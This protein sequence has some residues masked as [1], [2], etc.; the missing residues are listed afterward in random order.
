[1]S[2]NITDAA[3]QLCKQT[4]DSCKNFD[5]KKHINTIKTGADF[6]KSECQDLKKNVGTD[7]MDGN[8]LIVDAL[9][10][11]NIE[12]QFMYKL[13]HMVIRKLN[14]YTDKISSQKKLLQ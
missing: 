1:M 7:I 6:M 10:Q 14:Q 12:I 5:Y 4:I 9:H 8:Q 13:K 11:K 2:P 3:F